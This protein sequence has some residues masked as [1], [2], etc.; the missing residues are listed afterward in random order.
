MYFFDRFQFC[1][2]AFATILLTFALFSCIL[3]HIQFIL[4]SATNWRHTNTSYMV[5][6]Y[7]CLLLLVTNVAYLLRWNEIRWP[8]IRHAMTSVCFCE[9]EIVTWLTLC[10]QWD[11]RPATCCWMIVKSRR[12][13][14]NPST[15]KK[16]DYFKGVFF[17]IISLYCIVFLDF[18]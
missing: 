18:S 2:V 13:D 3:L 11:P 14:Q 4:I 16:Q 6:A 17:R 8:E 1:F 7:Y 12:P 9:I 5:S 10:S 15:A